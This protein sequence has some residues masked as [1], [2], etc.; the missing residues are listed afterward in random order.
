MVNFSIL[1]VGIICLVLLNRY[2]GRIDGHMSTTPINQTNNKL[3]T[4][5]LLNSKNNRV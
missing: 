4:S 5:E 1:S 2:F 3:E